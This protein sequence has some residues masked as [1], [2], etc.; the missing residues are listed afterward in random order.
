MENP[1]PKPQ[2]W[3]PRL[4]LE[5]HT[6]A[7]VAVLSQYS[8]SPATIK[9]D[10]HDIETDRLEGESEL[11][12]E[13]SWSSETLEKATRLRAT[14]QRNPLLEWVAVPWRSCSFTNCYVPANWT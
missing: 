10:C 9:I 8:D 3:H 5:P 1:G 4:F 13:L 11:R 14:I 2:D 6:V 12:L 7:C